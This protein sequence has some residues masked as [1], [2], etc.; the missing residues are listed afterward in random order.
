[1]R[2]GLQQLGQSCTSHIK[3]I[4]QLASAMDVVRDQD[5]ATTVPNIDNKTRLPEVHIWILFRIHILVLY[6]SIIIVSATC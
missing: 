2:T 5:F 1:M 6:S 3:E 4:L